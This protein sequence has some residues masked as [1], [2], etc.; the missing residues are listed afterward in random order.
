MARTSGSDSTS[1]VNVKPT[2][3]YD[4]LAGES[5]WSPTVSTRRVACVSSRAARRPMRSLSAAPTPASTKATAMAPTG[6]GV[7]VGWPPREGEL[8]AGHHTLARPRGQH[9]R[10]GDPPL[11]RLARQPTHAEGDGTPGR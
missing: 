9:A 3:S 7:G 8:D 1:K 5:C 4:R 6:D 2:T 11:G 10:G